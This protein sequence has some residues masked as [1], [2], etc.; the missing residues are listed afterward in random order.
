MSFV[1]FD[2]EPENYFPFIWITA[3]SQFLFDLF[4]EVKLKLN[5]AT[6]KILKG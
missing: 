6:A 1:S 2:S 4:S 5:A 3:L